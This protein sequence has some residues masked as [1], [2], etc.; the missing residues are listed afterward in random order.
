M[1]SDFFGITDQKLRIS[2]DFPGWDFERDLKNLKLFASKNFKSSEKNPAYKAILN[3]LFKSH[4]P[5]ISQGKSTSVFPQSWLRDGIFL[6]SQISYP[7]I[8]NPNQ[9]KMKNAG[10]F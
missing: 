4:G 9:D 10:I 7:E 6:G 1:G 3:F 2:Q 5:G 8:R